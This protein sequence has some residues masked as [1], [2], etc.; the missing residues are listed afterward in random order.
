MALAV[1]L[2]CHVSPV[3]GRGDVESLVFLTWVSH[4]D[5]QSCGVKRSWDEVSMG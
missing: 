3:G 4:V 2:H 1:V 5:G